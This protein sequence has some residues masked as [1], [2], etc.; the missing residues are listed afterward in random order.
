MAG[1]QHLLHRDGVYYYR[2]RVPEPLVSKLGKKVVQFSL[3]TSNLAEAKKRRDVANLKWTTRF[4]ALASDSQSVADAV[5][6]DGP[7]Q[8]LSEAEAVRLVQQYVEQ[9]DAKNRQRLMADPPETEAERAAMKQ[10]AEMER[11]TLRNLDN[12]NGRVMVAQAERAIL[13]SAGLPVDAVASVFT[14]ALRQ[15]L[16]ELDRRKL[17]RLDDD[18]TAVSFD[19]QFGR[20]ARS[21]DVSFADLGRQFMDTT[22]EEA[23]ANKVSRK[24]TDKLEAHVGVLKEILG[25]VSARQVD[26]DAC[27]KVRS[28]LS[29]LPGNR[30]KVYPK[31]TIEE[32]IALGEKDGKPVLSSATQEAYIATLRGIL[33]LAVRKRLTASNPADGMK[34]LKRD[35]LA[36][37]ERRKPFTL[38]QLKTF[39]GGKYYTACAQ[40]STPYMHDKHGWRFWLPL[41]CLYMGMRPI[42]ACQMTAE[43]VRLTDA[44]TIYFD[45]VAADDDES[46]DKTLKTATS[47][48]R[49]PLH[50]ELM[51]I[52]FM[53]YRQSR[54][55]AGGGSL[56]PH[57]KPDHYGNRATYALKR[58]RDHFL[59]AE[60]TLEARQSFYSFRH[61]FRD[62]LRR[63]K[64]PPDALQA[65]GGWS[66]GHLVSDDYG[67]KNNPDYQVQ[68]IKQIAF[69]GLDVSH[70]HL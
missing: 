50:P 44:G 7:A 57:L 37:S 51:A 10:D 2:R 34:P 20:E 18:Y 69:P 29:R 54:M 33:A 28:V 3:G 66:Q 11:Q 12:P 49:I 62:E 27:L 35:T 25:P 48:R 22:L 38:T 4:E 68:F 39:F 26:Y 15:G 42:E 36:A 24:W 45:V 46:D 60:I 31:A 41:M 14:E 56:F 63:I 1:T 67:D 47:R 16:L 40:H 52:G 43:D 19:P 8:V 23:K 5:P 6:G 58:F 61:S 59:P 13:Q 21:A 64:A 53:A 17:A 9:T 70:L 32:A 55:D 30:L 65:L